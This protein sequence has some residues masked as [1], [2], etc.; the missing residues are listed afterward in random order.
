VLVS[1]LLSSWRTGLLPE[2]TRPSIATTWIN[3]YS[4]W[5]GAERPEFD[6]RPCGPPSILF[7]GCQGFFPKGQSDGDLKLTTL[8]ITIL[9]SM[10][11][12]YHINLFCHISLL[13]LSSIMIASFLNRCIHDLLIYNINK[14]FFSLCS[15]R[16]LTGS[17]QFDSRN[18]KKMFSSPRR[19][20]R[21]QGPA[22][23]LS[24]D[25]VY[26]ELKR[27]GY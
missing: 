1:W 26:P 25:T 17:S 12:S 3:Q 19:S 18:V 8:Q 2:E 16:L 10:T 21:L 20:D 7:D 24:F 9:I 5:L 11:R 15:L 13:S 27:P 14:F 22:S 23:L 4:D 6:S